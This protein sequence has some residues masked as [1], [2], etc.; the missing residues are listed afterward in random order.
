MRVEVATG[1]GARIGPMA[2]AFRG[3]KGIGRNVVGLAG[4]VISR[5]ESAAQHSVY[6]MY[7]YA[8]LLLYYYTANAAD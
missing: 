6:D 4:F 3:R 8:I 5:S 2:F 7:C 1:L